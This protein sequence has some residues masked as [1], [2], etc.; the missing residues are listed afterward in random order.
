[1]ATEA[2]A[3]RPVTSAKNCARNAFTQPT[4]RTMN[5][6]FSILKAN[7]E[8]HITARG[9]VMPWAGVNNTADAGAPVIDDA[10]FWNG[11]TRKTVRA[12]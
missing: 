5:R 7:V 2:D 4:P 10:T 3:A 6:G 11:V 8:T 12:A 9:D 1:M